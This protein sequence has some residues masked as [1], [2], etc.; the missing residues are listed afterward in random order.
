MSQL[1][2][3]RKNISGM[4]CKYR[5][6]CWVWV[7]EMEDMPGRWMPTVGSALN[8]KDGRVEIARW[9]GR[10]PMDKFRLRKYISNPR[11]K[12]ERTTKEDG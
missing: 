9:R 1:R 6:P 2:L 3:D 8:R 10:N 4:N 12:D 7:V 5:T 11:R